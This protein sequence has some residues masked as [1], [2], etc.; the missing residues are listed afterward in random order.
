MYLRVTS[1]IIHLRITSQIIHLRDPGLCAKILAPMK[2]MINIKENFITIKRTILY[3][4]MSIC[5]FTI[6]NI[7]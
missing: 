5:R 3:M 2:G 1:Q 6:A 7:N 4:W